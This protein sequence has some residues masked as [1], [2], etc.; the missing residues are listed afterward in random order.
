[1][2]LRVVVDPGVFVSALVTPSRKA[3]QLVTSLFAKQWRMIASPML[4][5]ELTRVLLRSK[6][7]RYFD[8]ATVHDLADRLVH[9][10]QVVEDPPDRPAVTADPKDDYLVALA[11][12]AHADAIVSGDR[13]LTAL[14][15]S[16]CPVLTPRSFLEHLEQARVLPKEDEDVNN[17][18]EP[19]PGSNSE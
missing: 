15:A 7:H 10:A 5:D 13:H 1:M 4:I 11:A 8:A 6:F 18:G 12:S 17:R 9:A 3:D 14:T 19:P 16:P 2:I